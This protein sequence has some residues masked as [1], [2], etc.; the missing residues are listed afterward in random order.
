MRKYNLTSL[1]ALIF[2]ASATPSLASG[3]MDLPA[4]AHEGVASSYRFGQAFLPFLNGE[5]GG[6][7]LNLEAL[8]GVLK[9]LSEGAFPESAASNGFQDAAQRA[10]ISYP[11]EDKQ[12]KMLFQKIKDT[13]DT[14][15]VKWDQATN[16][17]IVLAEDPTCLLEGPC[18]D[19]DKFCTQL[20]G[21]YDSKMPAKRSAFEAEIAKFK[22]AIDSIPATFA[23]IQET[24]GLYKVATLKNFLNKQILGLA[25]QPQ[26]EGTEELFQ[27]LKAT[28]V[29]RTSIPTTVG[30]TY[31]QQLAT[32]EFLSNHP[33]VHTLVLGCGSFAGKA[34]LMVIEGPAGGPG[35][36]G[37]CADMHHI[38]KGEMTVSLMNKPIF[39]T[40]DHC[41]EGGSDSDVMADVTSD[42]FW[43]GILEGLGSKKFSKIKDHSMAQLIDASNVGYLRSVLSDDGEFTVWVPYLWGLDREKEHYK[44]LGFELKEL[45][46]EY[47]IFGKGA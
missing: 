3:D 45:D 18:V 9:L 13:F 19:P 41:N 4:M 17:T 38:K 22:E 44:Q 6:Y 16:E 27:M 2:I 46:G 8:P 20:L 29:I 15:R 47:L 32:R 7:E 14:D 30:Y 28:G 42:A 11:S 12:S 21:I 35:G 24:L 34:A 26:L 39:D 23:R 43:G 40:E 1:V 5:Y 33:E 25:R 36:R 10:L 31:S 37:C